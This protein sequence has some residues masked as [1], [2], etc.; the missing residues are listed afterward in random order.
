MTGLLQRVV[1]AARL[2]LVLFG[3]G[4]LFQWV[5]DIVRLAT[6]TSEHLHQLVHGILI[7]VS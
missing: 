7:V 1:H 6:L 2:L 5:N 3:V 4:G